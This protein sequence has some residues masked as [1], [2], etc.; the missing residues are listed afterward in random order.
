M[1]A[2][3]AERHGTHRGMSGWSESL[4]F[5][6]TLSVLN[7]GYGI[8]H[9]HGCH[10][11]AFLCYAMTIAAGTML[12]FTGAGPHWRAIVRHP[13]SFAVGGGI[14]GME[15][16]YFL[17]LRYVP[18]A[19]GSLL[20]RLNVPAAAILGF[21]LVGR[22]QTRLGIIGHAI[23]IGAIALALPA[24]PAEGRWIGL[25]LAATCA[26]IM[27]ARAFATEFHPWNRAARTIE[28]KVRLTGLVL[29]VT[30]G[31]GTL[32]VGALMLLAGQ[33]I[34]S[35]NAWLPTVADFLHPPTIMLGLFMGVLVLTAMQYL[36]FSVTLKIRAEN[37]VATT[38]L[39]PLVT[40]VF[41]FAAIWLE[42][43]QPIAF[44]WHL[45]PPMLLVGAGV[46]VVIWAGQRTRAQ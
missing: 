25:G 44:D 42:L 33:G 46:M 26:F 9:Q 21:L 6:A 43:M 10:P 14:I 23:V 7:V 28:E 40:V 2:A 20:V 16:V 3:S 17:L 36:A 45:L 38:A 4:L 32:L 8:G 18:P 30:S 31:L 37:F 11:I 22:R 15:A 13:L 39:I 34:L 27:S 41:Q 1:T 12:T 35:N 19:D 29:M 5:A 24:V